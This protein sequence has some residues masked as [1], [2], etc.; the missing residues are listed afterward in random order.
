MRDPGERTPNHDH[1]NEERSMSEPKP[2]TK[3]PDGKT[4]W[5]TT[6]QKAPSDKGFVG[7]ETVWKPLQKEV[8][9]TTPKKP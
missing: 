2:V 5:Y 1:D 7:F 8:G 9:Y 6:R 3:V 4:P